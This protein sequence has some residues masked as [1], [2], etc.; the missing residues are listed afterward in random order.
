[1]ETVMALGS[2]PRCSPRRNPPPVKMNSLEAL[3][4]SGSPSLTP[5]PVQSTILAEIVINRAKVK[6][7]IIRFFKVCTVCVGGAIQ[8]IHEGQHG[9]RQEP[10]SGPCWTPRVPSQGSVP[11]PI[12]W[13]ITYGLLSVLPAV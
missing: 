7:G 2:R 11:G 10:G 12:V 3:K 13:E 1:M 5:A 8:A 4:D 6:L 9:N